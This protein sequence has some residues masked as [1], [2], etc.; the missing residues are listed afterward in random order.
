MSSHAG[1][2]NRNTM[3]C[4][5]IKIS[6]RLKYRFE[7]WRRIYPAH[8][9]IPL[10][11]PQL[12]NQRPHVWHVQRV[13]LHVVRVPVAPNHDHMASGLEPNINR[14]IRP[15]SHQFFQFCNPGVRGSQVCVVS[16]N[17]RFQLLQP[18]QH[19]QSSPSSFSAPQ[20]PRPAQQAASS[21][22]SVFHKTAFS[23]RTNI[24]ASMHEATDKHLFWR[25]L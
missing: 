16:G 1:C 10:H 20:F 9:P 8:F 4:S 12:R 24:S 7:Y 11:L 14:D 18:F 6:L 22:F 23:Q 21:G 17:N 25:W 5:F 2:F 15:I 13:C 3:S 19:Y